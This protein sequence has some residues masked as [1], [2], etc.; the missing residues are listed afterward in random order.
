MKRLLVLLSIISVLLVAC[1]ESEHEK[2]LRESQESLEKAKED[3]KRLEE[4][5]DQIDETSDLIEEVREEMGI[6]ENDEPEEENSSDS[7]ALSDSDVRELLEY[8]ALSGEDNLTDVVVEGGE[9]LAT[10]EIGD[11]EIIDDKSMLAEVIYAS[12]GD[13][14][15]EIDGWDIL[16]IQFVDVGEVSM[17]RNEKESNEYGDYFPAEEIMKQLGNY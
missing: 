12:A 13:E 11:N 9:I 7:T 2:N 4:I 1:G 6:E 3:T 8:A 15:L 16:T 10:I 14:L 5:S 17:H